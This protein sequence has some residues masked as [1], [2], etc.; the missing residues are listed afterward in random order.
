MG[1]LSSKAR[2]TAPGSVNALEDQI[3]RAI[4]DTFRTDPKNNDINT[5]PRDIIPDKPIKSGTVIVEDYSDDTYY[6]INFSMNEN[7][8]IVLGE[9]TEVKQKIEYE[10]V[11]SSV[12]AV[13]KTKDHVM[14]TGTVLIPGEPDCDYENGEEILTAEKV[15]KIAHEFM[16]YRIIDKEHEFL[17]TKK[18]MGDPVESWLLDAPRVMKNIMGEEREY[19]MGTWVVKSKITDPEMMKLAEKGELAYSVSVLSKE[20]AD[21]IMASKNRVLIKDIDNPVGFTIS[22]TK[23]PCVDNSCSVKSATKAGRVISKENKTLLENIRDMIAGLIS[24][25]EPEKDKSD[26]GGDIMTE[27]VEKKEESKEYVEKSDVEKMVRKA[28][29]EVLEAK[30]EPLKCPECGAVVKTDD[31]FCSECG[32]GLTSEKK[33]KKEEKAEKKEEVGGGASKSLKPSGNDKPTPA[34]KSFEEVLDRDIYGRKL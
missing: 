1:K 9:K 12:L 29:E 20:D 21:K 13:E 31:K 11:K 3:R 26:S 19:P 23:N 18:N 6:S 22:L 17:V 14:L 27:K 30:K 16:N 4:K 5:Y 2:P 28:V 32:T 34:V 8:E 15:A 33:E 10:A 24:Q 7:N 25:A